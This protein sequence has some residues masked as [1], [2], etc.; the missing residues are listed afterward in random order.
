MCLKTNCWF[1]LYIS[2]I[3][4]YK[5]G[6]V[7]KELCHVIFHLFKHLKPAFSFTAFQKYLYTFLGNCPPTPP[8]SQHY[9]YFSPG[10]KCWF[11]GVGGGEVGSFLMTYS[12]PNIGLVLLF[13]IRRWICLLSSN[14]TDGWQGWEW[15]A[16]WINLIFQV[17]KGNRLRLIPVI[18]MKLFWIEIFSYTE[19]EFF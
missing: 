16:T 9:T 15:I 18:Y 2:K 13:I 12:D 14:A 3:Y 19:F 4:I 1:R 10:A 6:H 7:V 11:K 8:L 5:H 17:L